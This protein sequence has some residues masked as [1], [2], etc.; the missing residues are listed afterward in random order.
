MFGSVITLKTHP[1]FEHINQGMD[2]KVKYNIIKTRIL[3]TLKNLVMYTTILSVF[4]KFHSSFVSYTLV[5]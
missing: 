4:C 3:G 1:Q 2:T 5:T